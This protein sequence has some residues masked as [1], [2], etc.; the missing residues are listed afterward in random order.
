MRS[1]LLLAILV[2]CG[3]AFGQS[4]SSTCDSTKILSVENLAS[5]DTV[6]SLGGLSKI[7]WCD[8]EF[9]APT[10]P[11]TSVLVHGQPA[12]ITYKTVMQSSPVTSVILH[13]YPSFMRHEIVAQLPNLGVPLESVQLQLRRGGSTIASTAIQIQDFSP[14]IFTLD[15]TPGGPAIVTDSVMNYIL[16]TNPAH[17]GEAVT[18]YCEGLGPTNPFVPTGSVPKG[19]A[20]TTTTPQIFVGSQSA[21]VI[22]SRLVSGSATPSPAGVYEVTF[23]VPPVPGGKANLP[24][25][26]SIGGKNSNTAL[27]PVAP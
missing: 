17:S 10:T 2:V 14:G 8:F 23:V 4:P 13:G 3:S 25:Y 11:V 6:N 26:L 5:G 22:L 9:P 7:S 16:A 24:I 15:T 19:L 21:P 18:L 27:L 20:V 1:V 12:F